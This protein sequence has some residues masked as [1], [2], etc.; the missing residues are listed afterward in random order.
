MGYPH[1]PKE[2]Y[3]IDLPPENHVTS[4]VPRKDLVIAKT[5]TSEGTKINYVY[6]SMEDLS[7]FDEKSIDFVWSGESIKHVS[8]DVANDVF[9]L[10]FRVL[11][12]GGHSRWIPPNSHLTR[13]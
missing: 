9:A 3:I 6:Q 8:V 12:H 7:N 13:I 4:A 11:K 5:E 10:F 2:L 1:R